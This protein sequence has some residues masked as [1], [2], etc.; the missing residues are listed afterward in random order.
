[1]NKNGEV[2]SE[3]GVSWATSGFVLLEASDGSFSD[4]VELVVEI[5]GQEVY[6]YTPPVSFCDVDGMYR[7][8]NIRQAGGGTCEDEAYKIG[9]HFESDNPPRVVDVDF[10]VRVL[11]ELSDL[12]FSQ[13]REFYFHSF[14]I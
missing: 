12:L 5:G 13:V 6:A 10:S 11:C 1:M 7:W 8:R 14:K 4:A 3:V 2:L 9:S